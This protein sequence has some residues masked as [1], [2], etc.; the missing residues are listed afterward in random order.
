MG[1][2]IYKITGMTCGSCAMRIEKAVSKLQGVEKAY[3]DF[4]KKEL[5]VTSSQP[6]NLALLENIVAQLGR[7]TINEGMPENK[8]TLISAWIWGF[9]GAI[10]IMIVF[11]LI[12]L[13][14]MQDV[15]A[16]IDFML[17]QWFLVFPLILG[18]GIQMG[19]FRAIHLVEKHG[20]AGAMV[21][22]GGISS[23][24]MFACCLHNLVPLFPILGVSG[25]VVFFAAYQTQVFIFSIVVTYLGVIY[26]VRKYMIVTRKKM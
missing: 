5:Q 13:I 21:A 17:D 24:T 12:Q 20:G 2:N 9:V 15:K 6:I 19:M 26:M 25:L 18:F 7:Y 23:S 10:G 1:I 8:I 3:V 4:P 14:G 11:Y 16:P 22:S